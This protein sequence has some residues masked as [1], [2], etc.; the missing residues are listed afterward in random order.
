M[1]QSAISSVGV[2][3]LGNWGTALANHLSS[4]GY[5]VCGW[6]IQEDV[7]ESINATHRN[8]YYQS[9]VSLHPN[10]RATGD[11]EEVIRRD[12]IVLVV[13]SEALSSVLS[14]IT[15]SAESYV[16]SAIKGLDRDLRLTPLQLVKKLHPNLKRLAVLSGPSFAHD[17]VRGLP[18]GVV[19]ASTDEEVSLTVAKLFQS[20]QMKVYVS[21]DPLGV[22]LGGITKNVIALAA[23]VSDGIGLGD[24]ARAAVITRGLAEMMRLAVAAGAQRE[25]LFG[26]AGLGDLVM[27]AS[28][29]TSRNRQVGLCLGRGMSL[30]KA[31]EQVGSIAEGV[32]TA[33]LVFDL[34]K[35]FGVDVPITEHVVLLLEEKITPA[36]MAKGLLNRPLKAE[37]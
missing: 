29:D 9:E 34:A 18:A 27:T 19:A 15:L 26:L 23:G 2:L 22:E 37:F 20:D 7:V 17:V 11:I 10:F 3:G 36:Q 4:K 31:V 8:P 25:T 5:E 24:S 14:K 28:C 6:T 12:A 13:P 35:Q 1:T 16:V 30:E 33:P 32:K 21:T